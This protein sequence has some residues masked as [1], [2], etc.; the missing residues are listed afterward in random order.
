MRFRLSMLLN[1]TTVTYNHFFGS[2]KCCLESLHQSFSNSTYLTL[3]ETL[4]IPLLM[5]HRTYPV[6]VVIAC[7]VAMVMQIS[8]LVYIH[9][10]FPLSQLPINYHF[11]NVENVGID[12]WELMK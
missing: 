9:L 3:E 10:N 6:S 2:S 11:V 7:I 8:F 5:L 12:K 4:F 1:K